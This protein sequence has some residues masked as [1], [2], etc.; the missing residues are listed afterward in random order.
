MIEL[1]VTLLGAYALMGV[2]VAV[3]FACFGAKKVDPAAAKGTWGFKLLI[4]PGAAALWPLVLARWVRGVHPVECTN[5][6]RAAERR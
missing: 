5:H 4:M 1:F 6:R 3:P 2:L